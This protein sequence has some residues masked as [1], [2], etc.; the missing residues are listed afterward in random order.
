LVLI[1]PPYGEAANTQGNAGKTGIATTRVSHGMN[2]LSYAARELFVQFMHRMMIELPNAKLAMFSTLKYVNAPNFDKFR[3]RWTAKFL[4]GF[5]VPSKVFD[6]LKSSFP[7]GF[8]VWDMATTGRSDSVTTTALDRDGNVV[9][10]K[11]FYDVPNGRMLSAWMPR[12]GSGP[13]EHLLAA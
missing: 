5:V 10:E 6:G 3:E 7:I 2:D 11:T 1:N 13:I 4:D 9:G 8:L 12:L